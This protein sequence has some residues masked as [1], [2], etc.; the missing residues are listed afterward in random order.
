MHALYTGGNLFSQHH[1]LAT[2][3][4]LRSRRVAY[5]KRQKAIF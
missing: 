1:I 4:L 5:N 3:I 2:E